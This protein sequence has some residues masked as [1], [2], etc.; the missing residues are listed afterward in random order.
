[1]IFVIRLLNFLNNMNKQ[2]RKEIL[3]FWL[4]ALA[5]LCAAVPYLILGE[6]AYVTYHDQ[7]DGEMIAY[8]LQARHLFDG[9]II[10]EFMGGMEKTAL[11]LPAPMC[12]L[13]FGTGHYFAAYVFMHLLG[14]LTGYVGMYLLSS[15]FTGC[16]WIGMLTGIMFAYLPFRP[17]Y[18]LS[19]YGIPLLLWCF[20][21]IRQKRRMILA[22][23]YIAMYVLNSSLVL[24]GFAVLGLLFAGIVVSC[25]YAYRSGK[26]EHKYAGSIRLG[27]VWCAM[28]VIYVLENSSLF[29]QFFG[30]GG[31]ITHKAEYALTTEPIWQGWVNV[32]LYGDSHTEDYHRF[33]M[34]AVV[35]ALIVW[36]IQRKAIGQECNKLGR[37]MS[38]LLGMNAVIAFVAALWN[39]E[40][41]AGIYGNISFLRG[42]HLERVLWLCNTFWY[43][44]MACVLKFFI[45]MIRARKYHVVPGFVVAA[46]VVITGVNIL[47]ESDLKVNI[48]ILL[49]PDYKAISYGDY[50]AVD[51]MEQVKEYLRTHTG[52]EPED[53][54]VVSLGIDPAAAY[55]SGFYCLDGYSNNYSLDYKHT[56]QKV[57]EPELE[58]NDYLRAYFEQWGNRCYLLSSESPG[59]YTFEKYTS[60]FWNYKLDAEALAAMGGKYLLSAVYIIEEDLEGL[61]LMRKEAFET[62]E[63]YYAIYLYEVVPAAGKEIEG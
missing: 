17:V 16:K 12:V 40:W 54:R 55:Y 35:L 45:E 15:R 6:D 60:Y 34:V 62:P 44:L 59:Y 48:R 29:R 23:L 13:L 41:A 5:V 25:I 51:V 21:M 19:Q 1:M 31:N 27:I 30:A 24:V 4:G 49:N 14:S 39:S 36:L 57:L 7:L 53:Y 18:G 11:T 28:T 9:N 2:K 50:Y 33:L 8:I 3:P 63:S 43:L 20:Y 58:E 52:Q 32:F 56:F 37:M 22:A 61:R 38:L 46:C 47:K 26:K 42:F 10:P